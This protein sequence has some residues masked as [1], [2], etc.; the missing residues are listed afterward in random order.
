MDALRVEGKYLVDA[1]GCWNWLRALD[2]DGYARMKVRRRTVRVFR[3][4]YGELIEPIPSDLVPDHLCRNRRCINPLHAEPVTRLENHRR[5]L[6]AQRSVC[7]N[8]HQIEGGNL[9]P[10][11]GG[12]RCRICSNAYQ[13]AYQ[14]ANG[15]RHQN[16]YKARR[17]GA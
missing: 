2:K 12:A 4:L 1:A 16:A 3:W 15:H 17:K 11:S 5:G 8:G 9:L 6:R 14:R 13:S 10:R 7:P